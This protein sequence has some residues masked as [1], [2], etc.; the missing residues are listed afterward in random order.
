MREEMAGL[1]HA[2]APKGIGMSDVVRGFEADPILGALAI[3]HMIG[4]VLR[5]RRSVRRRLA[6]GPF[7][8][9]HGIREDM[10]VESQRMRVAGHTR[11]WTQPSDKRKPHL[12]R[13][14]LVGV[15][16]EGGTLPA[17]LE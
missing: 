2:I 10:E 3:Y 14:I 12:Y 15:D 17:N 8:E 4:E 1:H 6:F 9:S 7:A 5:Y 11:D 13:F 16:E